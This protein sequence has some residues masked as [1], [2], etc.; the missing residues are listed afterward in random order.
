MKVWDAASD[1]GFLL[2]DSKF[3]GNKMG[4]I[5][6]NDVIML[7]L[8][9]HLEQLNSNVKVLHCKVNNISLQ[10]NNGD[11]GNVLVELDS[12]DLVETK[13]LVIYRNTF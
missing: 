9:K 7:A 13:L 5:V 4:Y 8:M 12:D 10:Q 11:I 1:Y 3:A 6:E 2:L